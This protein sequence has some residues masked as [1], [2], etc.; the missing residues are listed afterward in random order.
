MT[1]T[2]DKPQKYIVSYRYVDPSGA[3]PFKG[4]METERKMQKGELIGAY[5]GTAIVTSCRVKK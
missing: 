3:G 2:Q 4:R 5:F 1:S